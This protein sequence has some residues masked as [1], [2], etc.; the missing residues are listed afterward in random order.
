[1]QGLQSY[2]LGTLA[3]EDNGYVQPEIDRLGAKAAY[4][5]GPDIECKELLQSGACQNL[6]LD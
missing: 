3:L 6:L 2:F 1:M 5:M 4:R